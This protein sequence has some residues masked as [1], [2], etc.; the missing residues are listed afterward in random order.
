VELAGPFKH[1]SSYCVVPLTN[2]Q[3]QAYSKVTEYKKFLTVAIFFQKISIRK[4][5]FMLYLI[6]RENKKKPALKSI[7][8]FLQ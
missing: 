4:I 7:I 3:G 1:W 5:F 6:E 2:I 8:F